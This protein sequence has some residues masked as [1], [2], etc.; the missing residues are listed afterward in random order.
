MRILAMVALVLTGSAAWPWP[1][2][3]AGGSAPVVVRP[4]SPPKLRWEPGHRG[5][6]L[7]APQQSATVGSA[8]PGTVAFAGTLFG[9][10][11]VVV[12]HGSVRTSY[13]PVAASVT[14]GTVVARGQPIG[15]L[16]P[17]HCPATPCLHWGL[18][19]GR[20]HS[21]RYYDPLILIGL[22]HLR[23]EVLGP[24]PPYSR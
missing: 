11:V 20:G 8:G 21:V 10:G 18:L 6:D 13:E 9:R 22:S 14:V 16:Q 15:T 17:G 12:T 23:L 1:P 3:G 7:A 4:F 2:A 24:S 5:V 19:T